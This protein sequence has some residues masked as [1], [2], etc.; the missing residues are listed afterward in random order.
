MCGG[1]RG[2]AQF[3]GFVAPAS[4][5]LSCPRSV[6]RDT[7]TT[8]AGTAALP[9]PAR[10]SRPR[11]HLISPRAV[12]SRDSISSLF[13]PAVAIRI[14]RPMDKFAIRGE[15]A[16]GTIRVSE[17]N[18]APYRPCAALLTEEPVIL[19]NVPQVRD[20]ETT[21]SCSAEW[22]PRFDLGYGRAQHRTTI[23]ARKSDQ[24]RSIYEFVKQMRASSLG[25]GATRGA[26]R[27]GPGF[28]AG[29][30][31]YRR[32]PSDLHIKGLELLGAKIT[33]D[34]GYVE[35]SADRL[36]GGEILFDRITVT[37]TEDL[38]VLAATLA[39]GETVIRSSAN[40]KSQTW[41]NCSTRWELKL[42]APARQPFG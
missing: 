4:R 25:A 37:G 41:P 29:R 17:A 15:S 23:C 7:P 31:C 42:K 26:L 32:A 35:A 11:P 22:A 6:G 19:E 27:T 16:A 24:P 5:R 20:I 10:A 18:M 30:L 8:A 12:S 40:P 33:Q 2:G 38:L 9:N 13:F 14:D 28:A 3:V 21:R 39:E 1:H 34:H 36:K